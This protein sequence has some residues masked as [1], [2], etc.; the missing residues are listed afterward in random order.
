M[1]GRLFGVAV[2]LL[3]AAASASPASPSSSIW[4]REVLLGGNDREH[5]YLVFQR[6]RPTPGP[7]AM[8]FDSLFAYERSNTDSRWQQRTLLRASVNNADPGSPEA[9]E[10]PFESVMDLGA[11]LAEHNASP[12]F[13]V[14]TPESLGIDASGVYYHERGARSTVMPDAELRTWVDL[15]GPGGGVRRVIGAYRTTAPPDQDAGP[16]LY[17]MVRFGAGMDDR[18]EIEAIVPLPESKVNEAMQDVK[19]RVAAARS[20]RPAHK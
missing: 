13:F 11:F 2:A 9:Q 18:G 14:R 10:Q 1:R 4:R 12:A 5:L 3:A 16:I 17:L 8:S 6:A 20:S 7:N 19:K 15:D